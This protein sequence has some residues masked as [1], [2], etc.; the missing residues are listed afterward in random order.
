MMF[1]GKP[2]Q[3]TNEM[4]LFPNSGGERASESNVKIFSVSI[5]PEVDKAAMTTT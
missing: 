4:V 5:F 3:Q 2:K 1:P